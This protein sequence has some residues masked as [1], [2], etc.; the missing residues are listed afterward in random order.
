MHEKAKFDV[1]NKCYLYPYTHVWARFGKAWRS[2]L[3]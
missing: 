2:H 1:Y 3:L